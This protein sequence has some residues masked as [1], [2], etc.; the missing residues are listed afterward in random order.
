[1]CLTDLEETRE[2]VE[3]EHG[4]VVVA[5]QVDGGLEGHGLQPGADEVHFVKALAEHLPGHDGPGGRR[6][7]VSSPPWT[8]ANQPP[9]FLCGRS[10]GKSS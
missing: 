6:G 2:D 10:P 9:R 8:G 7:A 1:M 3:L 4:D 5:G